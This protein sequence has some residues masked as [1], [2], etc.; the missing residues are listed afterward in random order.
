MNFIDISLKKLMFHYLH[1]ES[2]DVFNI[3]IDLQLYIDVENIKILT[4]G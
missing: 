1:L 2:A 4:G 3:Q